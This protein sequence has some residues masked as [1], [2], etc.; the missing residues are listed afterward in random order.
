MGGSPVISLV[1][2][3]TPTVSV[4]K[5]TRSLVLT[6]VDA[7]AYR[8]VLAE[9][10]SPAQT[11]DRLSRHSPKLLQALSVLPGS[12]SAGLAPVVVPAQSSEVARVVARSVNVVYIGRLGGTA[13]PRHGVDCPTLETIS[14][15]HIESDLPPL[16]G[17][18]IGESTLRTPPGTF[19]T[20]LRHGMPPVRPSTP[21]QRLL[22]GLDHQ[23]ST[24]RTLR[25]SGS[26]QRLR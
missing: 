9:D 21:P 19:L 3:G 20:T 22:H 4:S 6:P 23:L 2:F 11:S 13:L 18:L 16:R 8:G 17:L 24:R 26:R 1:A 14:F 12:L 10:F 7:S 25:R 5:F 15:E